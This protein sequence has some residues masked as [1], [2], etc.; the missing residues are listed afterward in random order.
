MFMSFNSRAMGLDLTAEHAIEL[1]RQASFG[2]VDLLVRDIVATGANPRELR[3]RI[4]GHGLRPGAWPL[5]MNW[6]NDADAFQR[7]LEHLPTYARCAS[8]LGLTRTGTWVLPEIPEEWSLEETVAMH[9]ERLSAMA[10]VLN[11]FGIHLGLEVIGVESS[12]TPGGRPFAH[13]LADLKRYFQPL[14]EEIPNLGILLDGF[15][16]YAA[17]EPIE[18][19]LAWGV[20]KI[21]WA[22]VAD[23]PEGSSGDRTQIIDHNRGLPGESPVVPTR[24]LL[25]R[26]ADEGYE[27]P[28]TAEPLGNSRTLRGQSAADAV[29]RVAAA[30]R[31]VWPAPSGK[32]PVHPDHDQ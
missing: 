6:K 22:H 12:R 28:V 25:Q 2:G 13:R 29:N 7:D 32:S 3:A 20:G 15:H 9:V 5:P 26:L 16:L 31:G 21:V 17:G 30:L 27:G 18:A 23:L 14:F 1:A 8:I 11:D 24:E 19:G 10:R 4:D